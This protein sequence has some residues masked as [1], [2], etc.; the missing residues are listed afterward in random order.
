MKMSAFTKDNLDDQG[1]GYLNTTGKS[2]IAWPIRFTPGLSIGLVAIG[3]GLQSP[4]LLGGVALVGLA[5][6]CFPKGM[7]F[8]VLYNYGVR[9]LFHAPLLPPT[10]MPR[11]F[12]Y[13]ISAVLLAG[14]A[15]AFYGGWPA[16]G[17]VLGGSVCLAGAVLTTTLWCLGSRIYRLLRGAKGT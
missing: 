2:Q 1:F 6:A 10:P 8:D 14:S 13:G 7:P 4:W 3:L 16:L 12:S 9:H 17:F 11:R 15:V 5:G